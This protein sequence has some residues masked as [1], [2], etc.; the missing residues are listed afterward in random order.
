MNAAE[1]NLLFWGVVLTALSGVM[2]ALQRWR[3]FSG[4]LVA[5]LALIVVAFANRR[6]RLRRERNPPPP[7]TP[8]IRS[9]ARLSRHMRR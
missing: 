7:P 1:R 9:R 2:F 8:P 6:A 5:G 3:S 4:M